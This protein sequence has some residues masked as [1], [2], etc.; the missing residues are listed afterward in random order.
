MSTFLS[1][2]TIKV[3]EI[4]GLSATTDAKR[5]LL[6]R[7][8][9]R[10]ER[11]ALHRS[12]GG[13][14]RD[15]PADVPHPWRGHRQR[16]LPDSRRRRVRGPRGD[17]LGAAEPGHRPSSAVRDR[18][19]SV[20]AERARGRLRNVP[21]AHPARRSRSYFGGVPGARGSDLLQRVR[22]PGH[23]ED[24][25]QRGRRDRLDGGPGGRLP[26]HHDE[27]EH[28]VSPASWRPAGTGG[29]ST[30]IR[31]GVPTNSVPASSRSAR[32]SS[33]RRSRTRS[34]IPATGVDG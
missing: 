21:S 28:G 32:A 30:R 20:G 9:G 17:P 13:Q 33:R 25:D 5:R 15:R 29:S 1:G 24:R 7:G 11:H 34:P 23:L 3:R 8:A 26:N 12:A 19:H 2:A 14:Q 10:H 22:D 6:A 18:D 4:P 31:R 16:Q 27:L